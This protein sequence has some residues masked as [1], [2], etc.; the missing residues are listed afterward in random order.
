MAI[1]NPVFKSCKEALE[2]T[3]L[4]GDYSIRPLPNGNVSTVTCTILNA[5]Y[6]ML[7]L[8][9]NRE[10]QWHIENSATYESSLFHDNIIY[11]NYSDGDMNEFL[12]SAGNCSQSMSRQNRGVNELW[13]KFLFWDGSF[14]GSINSF[15]NDGWHL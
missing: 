1:A 2:R 4:S 7:L 12:E 6:G 15:E 3:G 10:Q 9:N 5:I 8:S 13:Q 14:Y 11:G